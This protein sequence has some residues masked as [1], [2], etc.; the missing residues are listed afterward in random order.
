VWLSPYRNRTGPIFDRDFRKPLAR[1]C[2]AARVT[3]KRN[4]LRHSFGAYRMEMVKNA[5]QVA[6][7]MGN[8]AAIVMKHYL[9]LFGREY[10]HSGH[11]AEAELGAAKKSE[12]RARRRENGGSDTFD[13]CQACPVI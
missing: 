3:Y 2:K 12:H 1:V 8:S 5:G 4:A 10:Q 6:L 13:M 11:T 7:E 9:V